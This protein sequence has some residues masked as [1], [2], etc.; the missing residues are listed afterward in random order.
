MDVARIRARFLFV[1]LFGE[2][3]CCGRVRVSF[4]GRRKQ[5]GGQY[6]DADVAGGQRTITNIP[7]LPSVSTTL[8]PARACHQSPRLLTSISPYGDTTFFCFIDSVFVSECRVRT[9]LSPCMC[10]L[11]CQGFQA[12][13]SLFY[14]Q[15][16]VGRLTA[17]NI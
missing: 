13:V 14:R 12:F 9:A 2:I 6:Q 3:V 10:V 11:F 1:L 4:Q 17:P 7:G 5:A 8:V 16:D 15:G